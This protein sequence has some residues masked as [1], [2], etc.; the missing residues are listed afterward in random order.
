MEMIKRQFYRAVELGRADA[1]QVGPDVVLRGELWEG[2]AALRYGL[3]DALGTQS[4][5]VEYA[6]RL[7]RVSNVATRDLSASVELLSYPTAEGQFGASA[8]PVVQ[9]EPGIYLLYVAPAEGRLP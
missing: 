6:A 4:E 9:R 5:A 1:L 7:A 2:T 3:I 8:G